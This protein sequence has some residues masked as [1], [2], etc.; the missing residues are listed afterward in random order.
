MRI[1]A[2]VSASAAAVAAAVAATA[3]SARAEAVSPLLGCFSLIRTQNTEHTAT[4]AQCLQRC[5]IDSLLALVAPAPN[6]LNNVPQFLCACLDTLPVP[7]ARLSD[8]ACNAKCSATDVVPS[9][10]GVTQKDGVQTPIWSAYAN[11]SSMSSAPRNTLLISTPPA[12]NTSSSS[13]K[14]WQLVLL[15]G[16]CVLILAGFVFVLQRRRNSSSSQ[17]LPQHNLPTQQP[18]FKF[19][20]YAEKRNLLRSRADSLESVASSCDGAGPVVAPPIALLSDN[21]AAAAAPQKLS[22]PKIG[23]GGF[24]AIWPMPEPKGHETTPPT[25]EPSL[26]RSFQLGAMSEDMKANLNQEAP[27]SA[28]SHAAFS[29]NSRLNFKYWRYSENINSSLSTPSGRHRGSAAEY[30]ETASSIYMRDFERNAEIEDNGF[31][32]VNARYHLESGSSDRA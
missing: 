4:A 19:N 3:L 20:P 15:A 22:G 28:V 10:G 26:S 31:E 23:F 18:E 5:S 32:S 1:L 17:V 2:S 16:S 6:S 27:P 29:T 7:N 8:T 13:T 9:C 11:V 21:L 12:S 30:E 25:T 24:G 14:T